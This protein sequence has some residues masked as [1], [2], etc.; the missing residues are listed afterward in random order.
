[1][2][3]TQ[4]YPICRRPQEVGADETPA[5][6]GGRA[7]FVRLAAADPRHCGARPQLLGWKAIERAEMVKAS[8]KHMPSSA[9][10]FFSEGKIASTIFTEPQA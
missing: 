4:A 5:L 3:E 8:E 7:K 1:M 2:G 6:Q 9:P 10:W